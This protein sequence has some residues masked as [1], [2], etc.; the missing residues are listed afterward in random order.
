MTENS[1]I[2]LKQIV[3]SRF[4]FNGNSECKVVNCLSCGR[5][6]NSSTGFCK[7]GN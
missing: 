6:N 4:K 1:S 5:V 3:K 2:I 7:G